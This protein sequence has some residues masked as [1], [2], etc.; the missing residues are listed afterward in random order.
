MFWNNAVVV[1]TALSTSA[2]CK[3]LF[4]MAH[5]MLNHR[6]VL[7]NAGRTKDMTPLLEE[8]N[9]R[10]ADG[11]VVE[12]PDPLLDRHLYLETRIYRSDLAIIFGMAI[13]SVAFPSIFLLLLLLG[14]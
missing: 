9:S 10:Q 12:A 4:D 14:F 13:A 2:I 6:T 5:D 11:S 7:L 8:S 1:V 3:S